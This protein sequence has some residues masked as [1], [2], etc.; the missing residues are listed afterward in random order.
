MPQYPGSI[1]GLSPTF[2]RY[3][4]IVGTIT[5]PSDIGGGGGTGPTG[6]TGPAGQAGAAG[7]AGAAGAT[8]PTGYTGPAGGGAGGNAMAWFL[9]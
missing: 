3:V 2:G 4:Q 8:G 6:Y 5:L 7:S 1:Y 9:S